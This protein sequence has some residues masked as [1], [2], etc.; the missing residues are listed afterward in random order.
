[1]SVDMSQFYQI[2]FEES[3]ELLA[4]M[5]N[6]LLKIDMESPDVEELNAI[7]RV[8]HSIKGG[9]STFGFTDMTEVTH[10]LES[11]LDRVRK[12]QLALSADMVDTFLKAGDVLKGQLAGHRGDGAADAAAVEAVCAALKRLAGGDAAAAPAIATPAPVAATGQD[13]NTSM[14]V[15]EAARFAPA[16]NCYAIEFM[17]PATVTAAMV[18]N[19]RTNLG[20]LG[21][22]EALSG[23][24]AGALAGVY[25]WRLAGSAAE[26]DI[27]EVLAFVADPALIRIEQEAVAAQS[28]FVVA[29]A[30]PASND[31]GFFEPLYEALVPQSASETRAAPPPAITPVPFT[32]QPDQKRR[33]GDETATHAAPVKAAA[34]NAD[35]TSIRVGVERVDQLINLVGELVITHAMLAQTATRVD[36]V[37]HEG[38]LKGMGMLAHNTRS[39]QEAVMSIRMMPIS[40]VFSRFPRVVRDLAGKLNKEVELKTVGENTE[41]DKGLVE[42]IADPLNHLVRNSIDH[43]IET[44]EKRL[45]AGKRARGTITL[46]AFHQGGNIVIEVSDDGAGLNRDRIL[47][48][49]RS[50]G[51]PVTDSMPDQEVW[52]LIFAAGFSTAEVVT[53]VS[54]RGVGM[55]VV[56]RNIKGIGGSIEID[57]ALGI[58]TRMSIRLPLTLAIL[59]GMSVSIGGEI[60]IIPLAYIVESL[61]PKAGEVKSVNNQGE[62]IHVRGEYLPVVRAHEVFKIASRSADMNA[63]TFVILEADGC[64]KALV[65]DELLGQ[66]Q[67][68]IKSLETN[69]RKVHGVSGAT[70]MGDGRVAMILDVAEV[71]RGQ[72]R[73]LREAA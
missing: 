62:V 38:L 32:A 15:R 68:V 22:L 13:T 72:R 57:S 47:A 16:R 10:V 11:L 30:L 21:Q 26:E 23:P 73:G 69:Y 31:H 1:M 6:L 34:A 12:G 19:L 53:D 8:A 70:I 20:A 36:P 48:K 42:K 60:F 64:K 55:D 18:V 59:D 9:A 29:D 2:F 71:V 33:A 39:L 37:A 3:A 46:R 4:E 61:Q 45:A 54:G 40:F 17:L 24:P 51:L 43:G 7:F 14:P 35:A 58:G 5:E 67:V 56:R 63:G 44:P 41:L 49:A 50:Q 25:R 27:W 66:H 28:A 52:Q 65:V